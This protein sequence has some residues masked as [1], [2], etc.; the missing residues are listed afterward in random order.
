MIM[1]LNPSDVINIEKGN[2]RHQHTIPYRFMERVII[3][4]LTLNEY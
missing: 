2:F 3:C 1:D 4:S